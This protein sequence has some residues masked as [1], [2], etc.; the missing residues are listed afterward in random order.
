MNTVNDVGQPVFVHVGQRH[1]A[2]IPLHRQ[3]LGLDQAAGPV[4]IADGDRA[5]LSGAGHHI[6]ATVVVQVGNRNGQRFRRRGQ[7]ARPGV[8]LDGS[9]NGGLGAADESR[10]ERGQDDPPSH[11]PRGGVHAGNPFVSQPYLHSHCSMS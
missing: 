10:R 9:I 3:G 5:G 1:G 7:A 6:E 4:A 8:R 2:H 11:A